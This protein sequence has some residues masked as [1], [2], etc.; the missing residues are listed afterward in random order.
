VATAARASATAGPT[1]RL[2]LAEAR[3]APTAVRTV[4]PT[5]VVTVRPAT[6]EPA[7]AAMAEPTGRLEA[8]R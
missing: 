7:A 5:A 3:V 4:A 1:V 6:A 2:A 8:D